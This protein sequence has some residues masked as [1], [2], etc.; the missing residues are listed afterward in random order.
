MLRKL[1]VA[2]M[3]AVLAVPFALPCLPLAAVNELSTHAG[4]DMAVPDAMATM[5]CCP[6]PASV[7]PAPAVA[8]CC[9]VAG[10]LTQTELSPGFD[11]TLVR[12]GAAMTGPWASAI[13]APTA[14]A[15]LARPT[16]QLPAASPDDPFSLASVLLI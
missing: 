1:T 2:L 7:P 4:H 10:L 8:E 9:A 3:L 16:T 13:V 6:D 11:T 12:D 15:V 14:F 5:P